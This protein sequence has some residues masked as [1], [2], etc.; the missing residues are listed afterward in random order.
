[1]SQQMTGPRQ[2]FQFRRC[3]VVFF[4]RPP[5][6]SRVLAMHHL[7]DG[8]LTLLAASVQYPSF[9][10]ATWT[11]TQDTA[12]TFCPPREGITCPSPAFR[13]MYP[14]LSSTR[15]HVTFAVE[16]QLARSRVW[17]SRD[18]QRQRHRIVRASD[19]Y[20]TSN[21][22]SQEQLRPTLKNT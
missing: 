17:V 20:S 16:P 10:A 2:Y 19:S 1:M 9:Q 5:T 14:V 13:A 22:S 6:F 11:T 8:R 7:R 21:S 4:L 18:G 12:S 15:Q 3:S